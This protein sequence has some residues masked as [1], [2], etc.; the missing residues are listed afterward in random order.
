MKIT[1]HVNKVEHIFG[2]AN[3]HAKRT[4]LSVNIWAEYGGV[5]RKAK[6]K[7]PRLKVGIP[8]GSEVSATIEPVPV[9]VA[10]TSN[11]K[12]SDMRAIQEGLDYV[13]RNHDLF[14]LH[15]MDTEGDFDD[16]W[17]MLALK[18]RGEFN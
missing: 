1:K 16:M 14:N 17:L 5:A 12:K 7:L 18:S 8:G 4:G 10:K 15:Y 11:I 6:H 13:G 3:I 9:I 2:M